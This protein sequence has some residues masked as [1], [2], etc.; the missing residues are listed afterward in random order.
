MKRWIMMLMAV[1]FASISQGQSTLIDGWYYTGVSDGVLLNTVGC[2]SVSNA[3]AYWKHNGTPAVV[4]N[5]MQRWEGD[6]VEGVAEN[7]SAF[8]NI[9][10]SSSAGASSGGFEWSYDIVSADFSNTAASNGSANVMY[11]V[12]GKSGNNTYDCGLRLTYEGGLNVTNHFVVNGVT[13]STDIYPDA[14]QIQIRMRSADLGNWTTLTNLAGSTISDLNLRMIYDIDA[15]TNAAYMTVGGGS[16]IFLY[17]GTLQADWALAQLRQGFQS[18]NGGN[19]WQPGDVVLVDNIE[20][21]E[22]NPPVPPPAFALVDLWEFEGLTNGASLNQAGSTSYTS[23]VGGVTF[24]D[25]S[26]ASITNLVDGGATNGALRL[27][28][29]GA[30]NESLFRTASPSVY[31]GMSTG[32]YEVSFDIVSVDWSLTQAAVSNAN[33]GFEVRNSSNPRDPITLQAKYH[34]GSDEIRL[35]Y[36]DSIGTTTMLAIPGAVASN[37][38]VRAEFDLDNGGNPGSAK[39]FYTK[40]GVEVAATHEGVVSAGLSFAEYR[41][42][43]QALNG[44]NG[45]QIGDVALMDNLRIKQIQE[46]TQEP[47]YADVV[48][49]EM[50]DTAGTLLNALAQTGPDGGQMQGTDASIATDGLG[51]L[52]MTGNGTNDVTRKHFL[53]FSYSEGLHR[54]EFAFDDFNLD[55]SED[56]S[57]LK[58]GFA[59]DTGTNNVLFGIDVNTNNA[60]ARFR[61]SA[62]SGGAGQDFYDY[63]YVASTG[64]VLRIDVN[65]DAGFY[66]A[67]WRYSNVAEFTPVATGKSLGLLSNIAEVR[68]S[69][70]AG[71]TTG[72]DAADYINVDYVNYSSTELPPTPTQLY[73]A[74]AA[75]YP[76]LTDTNLTVDFDGDGFDNLFE[77]A[78]DGDPT[79]GGAITYA[80]VIDGVAT[81]G[82]TNYL[83]YV[84]VRRKNPS[85]LGL[86]YNIQLNTDLVFG[87]WT[88][89]T[90][91]YESIGGGTVNEDFWAVTN[92]ID[93]TSDDNLFV[94]P[95]VIFTQ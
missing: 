57:S 89:D 68:L 7:G 81:V 80:P 6:Y 61:A 33:F 54:L 72:F 45:W 62:S 59:D 29:T 58:F 85:A 9:N 46:M 48:V 49:Y 10:P 22:L 34:G 56:S 2:G 47:V 63:G 90:S 91:K 53:D 44:G 87:T 77:Y 40:D 13:N 71:E 39:F 83:D 75:G 24:S 5:Q 16:E 25:A 36:T 64:V 4:S 20:L 67:S 76:S 70:N 1:A 82:G 95:R 35:D 15:K 69:V 94:R 93:T 38:S 18:G 19:S 27:T 73:A 84:Y 31:S 26:M 3:T 14:D 88:N 8:K 11:I 12:R 79:V 86:T 60:T 23:T 28:A 37:L 42:R 52:V 65:L 92:R 21:S 32:I 55:A 74:W 78:F 30:A 66:S 50:N 17:S 41:L 43:A 51:S